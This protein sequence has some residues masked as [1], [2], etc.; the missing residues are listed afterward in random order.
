MPKSE[1]FSKLNPQLRR[2][3]A[4]I[5]VVVL[6][7]GATSA[8]AVPSSKLEQARAVKAQIDRLDNQVEIAAEQYNEAQYEHGLLLIRE[9]R[10]QARIVKADKRMGVLQRHLR[11]QANSMYRSGPV[12]FL[13]V[14][15]GA[16]SFEEFTALWDV[17]R[18]IN[19]DE[20]RS[21][22]ELKKVRA[23]ARAAHADLSAAEKRA[24]Q[25]VTIMRDRKRSIEAQLAERQQRLAGLEAEIAALQAEE[26]ARRA[27]LAREWVR[28]GGR[29]FTARGGGR[30][31]PPPT[32]SPRAAVVS[33]A[34]RYLGAAYHWGQAGPNSFDCSGF[35]MYV[36][37]QV[38][39]SLP[40]SSRAQIGY[41]QRVSRGDL[42][43]GDL[44]FFGSPIHHVGIY[45]G[46]GMMIHAPRSGDVVRIA[47]LHSNYAGAARP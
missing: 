9:K 43:P 46:G 40:H 13:E 39:I 7:L 44:V 3:A 16:R 15:L 24:A 11:I 41:G 38:G 18:K 23:E 10:A 27:R 42:R 19:A 22:A 28:R 30:R 2:V 47:P 34:K 35:T 6:C 45:V 33:V 8:W 25:Q 14:L 21:V 1:R 26:D 37:R 36:Y 5:L 20:A 29:G 31:F 4:A 32:R 12:G 17:L